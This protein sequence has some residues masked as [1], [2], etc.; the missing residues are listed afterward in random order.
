MELDKLWVL[1]REAS[2]SDHTSTITRAGMRGRAALISSA[3][4]ASRKNSLVGL[5]PVDRSIGHIVG[6]N[7]FALT[8]DHQQVH[9]KVLHEEDAVVT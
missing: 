3:V 9:G 1:N 2:T 7:A 6:D 4:S 8:L 5:H